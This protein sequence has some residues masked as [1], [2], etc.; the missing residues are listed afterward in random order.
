MG[1][2]IEIY[3]T[4]DDNIQI[5]VKLEGETF[6]L[7]LNQIAMLFE[8]DNSVISR[9]LNNIYKEG[10]LDRAS[11]VAKNATVQIEE[12]ELMKESNLHFLKIAYSDKPIL[13]YNLDENSTTE[14]FS[15]VQ[16]EGEREVKRNFQSKE[17][18]PDSTFRKFRTVENYDAVTKPLPTKHFRFCHSL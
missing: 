5:E 18:T 4:P 9:H 17:F 2:L 3:K 8:K 14:L 1:N 7:N 15:V 12:S 13:H 6:W 16:K 10:E 11:T